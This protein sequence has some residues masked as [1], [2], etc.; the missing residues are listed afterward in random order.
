MKKVQAIHAVIRKEGKKTVR[1]EPGSEFEC[2]AEEAESLLG[3]GAVKVLEDVKPARKSAKKAAP[4]PEPEVKDG[5]LLGY[6]D[7]EDSV[8]GA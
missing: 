8:E 1:V 3:L 6:A 7:G 5:D 4:E 2:P